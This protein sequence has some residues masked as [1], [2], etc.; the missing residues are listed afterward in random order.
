MNKSFAP[1]RRQF[2]A[3]A[4]TS[5]GALLVGFPLKAVAQES[6]RDFLA[7]YFAGQVGPFVR[8]NRDNS[9]VIGYPNP[10]MGQG[11]SVSLP[12]IV[13]E[14]LDADW[15]NVTVEQMPLG[16]K[17]GPDGNVTWAHVG[18]GSGGSYSVTGHWENLRKAGAAARHLLLQAAAERLG[19]S[20]G[21]LASESGHVVA[22]SGERIPYGELA[23]AA[24][25]MEL[26]EGE[27]PLKDRNDFKIMGTPQPM[28]DSR[29]IV[30]G[31]PIFGL[32]AT[33]P[34]MLH[35]VVERSPY[36]DGT[37][38][39]LDASAALAVPGVRRVVEVEGPEPGGPFTVLAAGVAVVADSL[40]AAMK[41]REALHIE[42]NKGPHANETTAGFKQTCLDL[43]EGKGQIVRHDGDFAEAFADAARTFERRY[44][45]PFVAHAQLEPQN[46][47]AHVFGNR[48]NILGPIQMPGGASR[49]VN[50]VTGIDRLNINVQM[51]RLGG[52]FGRRLPNYHVAE[53]ALISKKVGAPVKITWTREDDI[54]HD[55]Y[56]PAGYHHLQAGL[57]RNGKL[58]AWAHR[59]ASASKYY[60]RDGVPEERYWTAEIYP[61]DFPAYL[62]P[63]LKYE[64]FSA[65]SGAPRDSWRAPAHTANAFVV[66]SFLNE[67]AHETDEDA[68]AL[69]LRLLGPSRELPYGQH[70]G[71]TFNPGRLAQVLRTA[72]RHANWGEGLPAGRGRG[73]AGH[74]TFGSYAANVI[75]VEVTP[76]GELKILKVVNAVDCG[77]AVNPNGVR[78]QM[79]GGI[80]D[81]L[82]TAL[83][84]E[85][86]IDGGRV[87]EGNFHDYHMMRI[88]QAPPDIEVHI[89]DL[90]HEPTGIGEIGLPPVAPALTEAIFQATGKRIRELPIGDQLKQA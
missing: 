43:L 88:G 76:E 7:A 64:Y 36:F 19:V 72:A 77:L 75:D 52:G 12:M 49:A 53:A 89:V 48:C 21:E 37:V 22:P 74:F 9:V 3:V 68:L 38:K 6:A 23:A 20:A 31:E 16:I 83:A 66:Q 87:V 54:R 46:C 26:P 4:G 60:R 30:T 34:D 90:G 63:N 45:E 44:W 84:Q 39:S 1:T 86:T 59:L 82:S 50:A 29:A 11:V 41:G 69:R 27:I 18:Q 42:W 14:E 35:A 61:D 17:R 71:P 25:R 2:L 8:V 40:W 62:V 55:M 78:M 28:K 85:I 79:E 58:I 24:A 80:N 47:I 67:I 65:P 56:R 70:G 32:D 73:L 57:D 51:T 5:A 33:Y 10:E 81:G 15:E 13:A